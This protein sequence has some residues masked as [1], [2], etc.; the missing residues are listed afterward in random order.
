[1]HRATITK[2]SCTRCQG[3]IKV[4]NQTDHLHSI[5]VLAGGDRLQ[6]I[7]RPSGANGRDPFE[8]WGSAFRRTFPASKSSTGAPER[9]SVAS[10]GHIPPNMA[11]PDVD[12]LKAR[13]DE[14]LEMLR[15]EQRKEKQASVVNALQKRRRSSAA[16]PVA[17]Q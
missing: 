4:R 5:C 13:R 10:A 16:R 7:G 8:D 12:T 9:A 1:M 2:S 11:E 15:K 17:Q 14:E 3:L 6:D